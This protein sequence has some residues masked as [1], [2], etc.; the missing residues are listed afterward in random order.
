LDFTSAAAPGTRHGLG[1]LTWKDK[2]VKVGQIEDAY[3]L[4]FKM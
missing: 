2:V 1:I 4:G 3:D